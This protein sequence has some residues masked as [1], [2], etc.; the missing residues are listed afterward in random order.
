LC[1][2]KITSE[3]PGG[4]LALVQEEVRATRNQLAQ[5]Q[6][7]ELSDKYTPQLHGELQYNLA[8]AEKLKA[9]ISS[10]HDKFSEAIMAMAQINF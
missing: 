5:A 4:E 7:R 6:R 2:G 1:E 8:K 10:Q 3:N 9:Q